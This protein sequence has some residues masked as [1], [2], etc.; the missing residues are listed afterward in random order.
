MM[1]W[2]FFS[3]AVI[4]VAAVATVASAF[5]PA[6][7][8]NEII[9]TG[10]E[11]PS[12]PPAAVE[13]EGPLTF[14]FGKKSQ[15]TEGNHTWTLVNKGVGEARLISG[16]TSCS[17]TKAK[18]DE[19]E[20]VTL[21]PGKSTKVTVGYNTKT[22]DHFHHWA[23]IM[24]QNDPSQQQVELVI[25]GKVFP[26]LVTYPADQTVNMLKVSNDNPH[27]YPIAIGSQDIPD[28]K[29][30]EVLTNPTMFATE[31]QP[32]N[33]DECKQLKLDKGSKVIVKL[34]PGAV[35]GPFTE[36]LIIKT[37]HPKKPEVK[38]T[39]TGK[40]EG[41]IELT[42]ERLR[43]LDVTTKGG[44]SATLNIWVRGQK[45]TKFT[46][47]KKPKDLDIQITPTGNGSETSAQYKVTVTVPPGQ[48]TK[49]NLNDEIILK[50]DHPHAGEVKIPVAVFIRSS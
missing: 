16:D 45:T 31:I 49:A 22:W 7:K 18:F 4:V 50:T 25:E 8:P 30:T 37:D 43:L 42:P 39:L 21:A 32:L 2:V 3:V 35:L 6:D 17:C 29:I 24:I 19:G 1:R 15:W 36:E 40:V 33:A 12:G 38:M 5:L 9:L 48:S 23:H 14:D 28:T 47:E 13:V 46:V 27:P 34:K 26:P 41:P 20:K 10:Q 44:G 11:T